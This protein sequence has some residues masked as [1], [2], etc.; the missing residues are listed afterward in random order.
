MTT[1]V[2]ISLDAGMQPVA[3]RRHVDRGDGWCAGC[4]CAFPCPGTNPPPLSWWQARTGGRYNGNCPACRGARAV[5]V[6]VLSPSGREVTDELYNCP[7]CSDGA[8]LEAAAG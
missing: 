2:Q 6:Q 8:R 5:T 1:Q 3:L 4:G 7:V